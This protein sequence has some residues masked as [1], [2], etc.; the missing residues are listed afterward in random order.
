MSIG[1]YNFERL[2]SLGYVPK[3]RG[4]L[5]G[6]YPTDVFAKVRYGLNILPN[7][8]IWFCTNSIPAPDTSVSSVGP[9]KILRVPVLV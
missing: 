6:K 8:T 4:Y 7:A 5:L 2:R 3:Y 1:K 9:L